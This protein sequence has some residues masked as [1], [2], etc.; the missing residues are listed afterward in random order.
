MNSLQAFWKRVLK[1][2]FISIIGTALFIW[3]LWVTSEILKK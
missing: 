2:L 1:T 3:I